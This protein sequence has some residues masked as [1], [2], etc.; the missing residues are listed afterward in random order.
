MVQKYHIG[1]NISS[2]VHE[3]RSVVAHEAIP[4]FETARV[5]TIYVIRLHLCVNINIFVGY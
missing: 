3:V 4:Y 2:S 5:Y 1:S